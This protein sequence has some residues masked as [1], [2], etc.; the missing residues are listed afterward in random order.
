MAYNSDFF[1]LSPSKWK[2]TLPVD[3]SGGISG[4]AVE[5]KNLVGYENSTY[6][7][8]AADKAMTFR[9]MVDGATT[10]GSKYPRTELREMNGVDVRAAWKLSQGG[11]MTATLKVDSVPIYNNGEPG[12]LIVG[13]IHGQNDELVRLYYQGGTVHFVNDRSLSGGEATFRFKNA[14]GQEPNISLGEKFSYMINA[15]GDRLLVKI[16]ADGQ[17]YVSDTKINSVWQ[18][19]TFYFKAGVYLGVNETQGKGWG[20][21]SF[22]GLDFSHQDGAGLGGWKKFTVDGTPDTSGGGTTPP[23]DGTD[24]GNVPPPPKQTT[25]TGNDSNNTLMGGDGD[26]VI[27]GR[28]G[29]DLIDGGRGNDYLWGNEGNDTLI[30]GMGADTLKGGAG[31][32]VFVIRHK[33]QVDTV[34]DL[35]VQNGDRLDISELL[36][37]A[38]GFTQANAFKGGYVQLQQ[39]GSNVNVFIDTDGSAGS[40]AREHIA[41]LQNIT[42]GVLGSKSFILPSDSGSVTPPPVV[43]TPTPTPTTPGGLTL[44]GTSGANTLTGGLGD[45]II[46][47]QGGDDVIRGGDGRDQ[48]WGDD[49]NDYLTG[50]RG[51]DTLYGGNGSDTFVFNNLNEAGDTIVNFQRSDD[52]NISGIVDQILD[53]SDVPVSY[54]F[55]HGYL[56]VTQESATQVGVYIDADGHAGSAQAIKLAT[57][58]T[59]A[60]FIVDASNFDF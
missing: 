36:K 29:N 34:V 30:G 49:G 1:N 32:D 45:D 11:T 16:F 15:K 27:Y 43:I 56:S 26:Q 33:D 10:S 54:L 3:S 40:T 24:T 4:T 23:S 41:T 7:F 13:Q 25:L 51:A 46:R 55:T 59:E 48:L 52:I 38:P 21:T 19:D 2:L 57:L 17:E 9:A 6:F 5:V 20:Q 14:S 53:D 8:D 47:G 35:S 18:S 58:T 37:G 50:G 12:R 22:Y 42:T 39:S 44:T 31:A 28:K 60:S